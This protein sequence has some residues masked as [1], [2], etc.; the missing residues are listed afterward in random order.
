MI[1]SIKS[2]IDKLTNQSVEIE[3]QLESLWQKMGR[4]CGHPKVK[5]E[6]TCL[7]SKCIDC[8]YY[9]S[10]STFINDYGSM[11]LD[12]FGMPIGKKAEERIRLNLG[13]GN[14]F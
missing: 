5:V 3:E 4:V 10:T 2:E 1:E 12:R 7:M 9:D 11:V 6:N 8:G 14:P 13:Y